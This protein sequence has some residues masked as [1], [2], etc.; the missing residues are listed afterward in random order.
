M[1]QLND[2]CLLCIN[3]VFQAPG[4]IRRGIAAISFPVKSEA[5]HLDIGDITD[6][7][8]WSMEEIDLPR[9]GERWSDLLVRCHV[10][11]FS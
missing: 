10:P 9:A 7:V 5:E 8:V 2:F 11:C 1:A 3:G 4:R 6:D